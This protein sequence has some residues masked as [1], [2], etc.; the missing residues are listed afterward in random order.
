MATT[1]QMLR[2]DLYT[3]SK[4]KKDKL[5]IVGKLSHKVEMRKQEN[6]SVEVDPA[7]LQLQNSLAEAQ[8]VKDSNT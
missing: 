5:S 8:R 3:L 7:I 2:I 6:V 1:A 4:D